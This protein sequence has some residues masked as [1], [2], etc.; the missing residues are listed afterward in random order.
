MT[1]E[2]ISLGDFA[3]LWRYLEREKIRPSLNGMSPETTPTPTP[4]SL[5][6]D[7]ECLGDFGGLWR[8]LDTEKRSWET[9]SNLVPSYP[10][11]I[12]LGIPNE[13][14]TLPLHLPS[15]NVHRISVSQINSKPVTASGPSTKWLKDSTRNTP[16]KRPKHGPVQF[17]SKPTTTTPNLLSAKNIVHTEVDTNSKTIRML[18]K[19]PQPTKTASAHTDKPTKSS[20]FILELTPANDTDSVSDSVLTKQRKTVRFKDTYGMSLIEPDP[21]HLTATRTTAIVPSLATRPSTMTAGH[22]VHVFIDHSNIAVGLL[23]YCQKDAKSPPKKPRLNYNTLFAILERSRH[24]NRRVLVASYPL[25]QPLDDAE[26]AGYEVSILHRVLK[27]RSPHS[28][29]S[30]SDTETDA[31]PLSWPK[32]KAKTKSLPVMRG[33]Q[34]VDE[35]LQ[36]KIMES[37]LDHESPATLVMATGDGKPAEFSQGGFYATVVRALKRG[38]RVEVVSWKRQLSKN[39]LEGEEIRKFMGST[40]EIVLLDR[41]ARELGGEV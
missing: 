32:A 11:D 8:Y 23:N 26:T 37:L 2:M 6:D 20:N 34:C 39:F 28:S 4:T 14:C 22:P 17:A 1:T 38:W 7:D 30:S 36:L 25:A 3:P 21:I 41:F 9:A 40:Y 16:T 27:P 19:V 10:E 24:V 29:S 13:Q 18:I 35:L 12:D 31:V 5:P 15:T 33:E